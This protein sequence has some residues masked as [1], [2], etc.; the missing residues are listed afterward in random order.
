MNR[1]LVVLALV[2]VLGIRGSA[3]VVA[4]E[5]TPTTGGDLA[6]WSSLLMLQPTV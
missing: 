6:N 2:L 5:A 3:G 4:Q 1:S